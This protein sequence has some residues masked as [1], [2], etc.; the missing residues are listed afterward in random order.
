MKKFVY[1]WIIV[2]VSFGISCDSDPDFLN[3]NGKTVDVEIDLDPFHTISAIDEVDI[4]IS[5]GIEQKVSLRARENMIPKMEVDV[6][7]D[8]LTFTDNNLFSWLRARGNPEL[9]IT[10]KDLRKI[11]MFS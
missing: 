4:Y 3:G 10:V 11:E 9:Y 6:K 1:I 7:D 2:I 8:I 5:Q